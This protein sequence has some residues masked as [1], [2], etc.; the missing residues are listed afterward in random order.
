MQYFNES[1]SVF[2]QGPTNN[3]A[4]AMPLYNIGLVHNYQKNYDQA[5][6]FLNQALEIQTRN[7]P[8]NHID[9]AR[10]YENI[11]KVYLSKKNREEAFD[12]LT[13]A[14][15]IYKKVLPKDH[16]VLKKIQDFLAQYFGGSSKGRMYTK[17]PNY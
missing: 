9:L 11:G 2:R 10:T 3:P 6:S 17:K 12:N 14:F 8:S 4:I 7:L 16:P 13:R 5:L 15:L 1:L